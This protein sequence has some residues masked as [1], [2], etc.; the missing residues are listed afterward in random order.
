MLNVKGRIAKLCAQIRHVKLKIAQNVLQSAKPH[1]ALPIAKHLNPNVN[2]SV[3]N[4]NVTGN[5]TNPNAP[6][7]NV[8]SY[9]KT[10]PVDL[11]S[12]AANV[13]LMDSLFHLCSCSKKLNKMLNVVIAKEK[14]CELI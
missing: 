3:K 9:V 12:N 4:Q 6:N 10:P 11:N 8:N 14:K 2:Q 1:I 13:M 5:A 7:L